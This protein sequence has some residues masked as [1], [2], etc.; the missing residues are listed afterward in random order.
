MKIIG[1][2]GKSGTGKTTL[3]DCFGE[4]PNVG[5]IHLDD[6]LND[7]KETKYGNYIKE[8]NKNNTP[9][10]LTN[11]LRFL[12]ANNRLLF[13]I[14]MFVKKIIIKK[15]VDEQ[16]KEFKIKGKDAIVI[17]GTH[18]KYMTNYRMYDK[19]I[20]V[21]RPYEAR[22]RDLLERDGLS[23][24]EMAER[25]LPYKKKFSTENWKNFDYIVDNIDGKEELRA[26]SQSLYNEIVGIKTFDDK[27]SVTRDKLIPVGKNLSRGYRKAREKSKES[28]ED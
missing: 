8:R 27:Y 10:I 16:I 7:I 28:R 17:D 5:V 2:T 15:K 3:S 24:I 25:D 9:I 23:K 11:R 18:L 1:I 4:R 6:V 13:K 26:I 14:S 20:Y 12:I 19:V 21:R 22:E